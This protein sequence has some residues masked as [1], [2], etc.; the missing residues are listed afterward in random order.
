[1][2]IPGLDGRTTRTASC[3]LSQKMR[4]R[5]EEI[6]GWIKTVG[7][8]GGAGI[9]GGS[10]RRRGPAFGRRLQFAADGAPELGEG[11]GNRPTSVACGRRERPNSAAAGERVA[12]GV[13][14]GRIFALAYG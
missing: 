5:V 9:G 12:A 4:K 11:V 3:R 8:C 14:R 10:G 7:S 6:L 13:A 2:K 1:M